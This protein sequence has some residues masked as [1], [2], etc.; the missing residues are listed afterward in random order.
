MMKRADFI[1]EKIKEQNGETETQELMQTEMEKW[2]YKTKF[3]SI[4][5]NSF[6]RLEGIY[7]HQIRPNIS[8]LPHKKIKDI[9]SCKCQAKMSKNAHLK[10]TITERN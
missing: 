7:L 10:C 3:G 6:D 9:K 1:H 5:D 4:K 2:L 8:E